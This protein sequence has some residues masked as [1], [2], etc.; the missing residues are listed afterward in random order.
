MTQEQRLH[1]LELVVGAFLDYGERAY[2]E[3]QAAT[4]TVR[5]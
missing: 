5:H 1:N 4:Q 2:A 3:M